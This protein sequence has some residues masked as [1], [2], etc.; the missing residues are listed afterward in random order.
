MV[1][2]VYEVGEGS[3]RAGDGASKGIA[4]QLSARLSERKYLKHCWAWQNEGVHNYR[5]R[6]IRIAWNKWMKVISR[7]IVTRSVHHHRHESSQKFSS[8]ERNQLACKLSQSC[9]FLAMKRDHNG[10]RFTIHATPP[11]QVD[12]QGNSVQ[13]L[14]GIESLKRLHREKG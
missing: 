5:I 10:M 9:L 6:W 3:D 11:Q 14:T 2:Q 12:G 13:K 1:S 7:T 8:M 4:I